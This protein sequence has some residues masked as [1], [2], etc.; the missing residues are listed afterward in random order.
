MIEGYFMKTKKKEI[1]LY[2]QIYGNTIQNRIL[3]YL[4]ENEG[5]D[6]AIGD[7]SKEVNISRPKAYEYIGNFEKINYVQKSRM[8]GRTKLYKLN[9]ANVIIKLLKKNFNECLKLV[10]ENQF[11]TNHMM[12]NSS[13]R[14]ISAKPI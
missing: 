7:L 4:F 8:I 1:G 10:I 12:V 3:A 9:S 6:F 14:Q 2:C 13:H 5:L 11:K